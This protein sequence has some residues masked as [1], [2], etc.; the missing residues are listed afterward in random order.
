MQRFSRMRRESINFSNVGNNQNLKQMVRWSIAASCK[1]QAITGNYFPSAFPRFVL[2]Y[3]NQNLT[4][5]P[6]HTQEQSPRLEPSRLSNCW[7]HHV[8]GTKNS[9]LLLLCVCVCFAWEVVSDPPP[10]PCTVA[11]QWGKMHQPT[12]LF[13][14]GVPCSCSYWFL[15]SSSNSIWDK[16]HPF[17]HKRRRCVWWASSTV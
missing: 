10:F 16:D 15:L 6:T 11:L 2:S 1:L 13:W 4:D 8:T 12:M 7:S 14:P 17:P 9:V 3:T 5:K